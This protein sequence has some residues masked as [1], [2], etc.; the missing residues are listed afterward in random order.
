MHQQHVEKSTASDGQQ[1]V[2]APQVQEDACEYAKQL[3]HSVVAGEEGSM[4]NWLSPKTMRQRVADP[5]PSHAL[6]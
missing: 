2:I 1:H 3:R 6:M 5:M 4:M